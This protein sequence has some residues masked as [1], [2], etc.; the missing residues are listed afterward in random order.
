MRILLLAILGIIT[1]APVASAK[2]GWREGRNDRAYGYNDSYYRDYGSQRNLPPGIAKKGGWL[3]PGQAKKYGGYGWNNNRNRDYGG[4]Y[5]GNDRYY[6]R[7][8]RRRNRGSDRY[9]GYDRRY[10]NPYRGNFWQRLF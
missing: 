8:E 5:G 4:Y 7:L 10:Y 2:H 9:D 1:V 3:P 6:E